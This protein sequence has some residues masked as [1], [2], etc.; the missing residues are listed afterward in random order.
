[1]DNLSKILLSIQKFDENLYLHSIRTATITEKLCKSM[2]IFSDELYQ[3][4]LV[5]DIGKT[6]IPKSI[7]LKPRKLTK[8]ERDIIDLHSYYGYEILKEYEFN[9]KVCKFVLYHHGMDKPKNNVL[10]NVTS[11]D[12][13]KIEILK[14]A[15]IFDALISERPYST[16]MSMERA[17][18]LMDIK[19][20]VHKQMI[21][22]LE[23]IY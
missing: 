18:K 13:S 23:N 1:M 12:I 6:K 22:E 20:M 5:H 9:D 4:A 14:A 3:S 19:N 21:N 15:D 7:L 10:E 2:F 17:I 11:E 8:Q 16:A